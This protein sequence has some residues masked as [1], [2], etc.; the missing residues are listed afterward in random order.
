MFCCTLH[1]RANKKPRGLGAARGRQ[2]YSES[3]NHRSKHE[4]ATA[5]PEYIVYQKTKTRTHK[6]ILKKTFLRP[7]QFEMF[8]RLKKGVYSHGFATLVKR[9][10]FGTGKE[11]KVIHQ[12][13]NDAEIRNLNWSLKKSRHQPTNGEL[14]SHTCGEITLYGAGNSDPTYH[15]TALTIDL[16]YVEANPPTAESIQK[17]KD[18]LNDQF[19]SLPYE[20]SKHGEHA[21]FFLAKGR[22]GAEHLNR[23]EDAASL[24]QKIEHI[25][26]WLAQFVD[27]AKGIKDC[28]IET[29]CPEWHWQDGKIVK[30]SNKN[31]CTLPRVIADF[32]TIRSEDVY[33]RFPTPEQP[34]KKASGSKAFSI[35]QEIIDNME[36]YRAVAKRFL[37]GKNPTCDS[38]RHIVIEEDMMLF[39]MILH[40]CRKKPIKDGSLPTKTIQLYWEEAVASGLTKRNFR[41]ERYKRC[42]DIVS[43]Q[44]GIEVIDAEYWWVEDP[45]EKAQGK[46]GQCCKWRMSDGL[47]DYIKACRL[48][49]YV[50]TA[51][52]NLP[53]FGGQCFIPKAKLPVEEW[54][55]ERHRPKWRPKEVDELCLAV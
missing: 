42:R 13:S 21:T 12:L 11:R 26:L 2:C 6:R 55:V 29:G 33:E 24:N 5:N 48:S 3:A 38:S 10:Q 54:T 35:D 44:G 36:V 17:L 4:T 1:E 52:N 22:Q 23:Y 14:R 25:N 8:D 51:S 53:H 16:D 20:P 27:P 19:G 37:L 45:K 41:F 40:Q 49:L 46:K 18:N 50:I 47:A 34:V 7:D 39:L 30:I 32:P 43:M 15:E 31:I 28:K 9:E